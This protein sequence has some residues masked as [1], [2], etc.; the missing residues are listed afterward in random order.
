MVW[1]CDRVTAGGVTWML[2][3]FAC[4][5]SGNPAVEVRDRAL[6]LSVITPDLLCLYHGLLTALSLQADLRSPFACLNAETPERRRTRKRPL[7]AIAG[8]LV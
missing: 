3:L 4:I 1:L 5:I 7:S 2:Q 8:S 6:L